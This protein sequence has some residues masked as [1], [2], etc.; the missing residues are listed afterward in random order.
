[1]T[2]GRGFPLSSITPERPKPLW[3]REGTLNDNQVFC[4]S[5]QT[6][7][8]RSWRGP[9]ANFFSKFFP[10]NNLPPPP[11]PKY[12]RSVYHFRGKNFFRTSALQLLSRDFISFIYAK[13]RY[14][15]PK[16]KYLVLCAEIF[17]TQ[18]TGALQNFFGGPQHLGEICP[19]CPPLSAAL[20]AN[21]NAATMS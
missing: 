18:K 20:H 10:E 11:S 7:P 8:P 9:G 19:P 1:M 16:N 5:M 12:F 6:G 13:F 15:A 2:S 17:N 3:R 14:L 4:L 21:S